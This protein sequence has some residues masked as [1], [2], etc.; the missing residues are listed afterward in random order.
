MFFYLILFFF[1]FKKRLDEYDARILLPFII[2]KGIGLF[3]DPTTEKLKQLV[4]Q[5]C[6]LYPASKIVMYLVQYGI[7]PSTSSSKTKC[8]CLELIGLI[9]N[10][11]GIH[12]IVQPSKLLSLFFTFTKDKSALLKKQVF[13]L[14]SIF[15]QSMGDQE[16]W[17]IIPPT[18]K[19]EYE[20][21]IKKNPP[22]ST[23]LL[24][25]PSSSSSS[26]PRSNLPPP[27]SSSSPSPSNLLPPSSS[28][29]L[30]LPSNSNSSSSPPPSS[31]H[32]SNQQLHPTLSKWLEE[33]KT[34][35]PTKIIEQSKL[36]S[37][38][39][40]ENNNAKIFENAVNELLAVLTTHYSNIFKKESK[41]YIFHNINNT[42][43]ESSISNN[44]NVKL[45]KY[46]INTIFQL[47]LN[48]SLA[49]SISKLN[50]LLLISNILSHLADKNISTLQQEGAS[51]LKALNR[52]MFKILENCDTTST[53]GVLLELLGQ[54]T[55][56]YEET[57]NELENRL[58]D[59][60]MKCILK[61]T[62][63]LFSKDQNN[64]DWSILLRD[65]HLFLSRYS[66][67]QNPSS[68]TFMP[69]KTVKTLLNE[70][71]KIKSSSIFN[72]LSLVPL[73]TPSSL[74]EEPTQPLIRIYID[75]MLKQ[76]TKLDSDSLSPQ[77]ISHSSISNPLLVQSNSITHTIPQ[78]NSKFSF[79]PTLLSSSSK[80][81]SQNIDKL[82]SKLAFL[83]SSTIENEKKLTSSQPSSIPTSQ[84]K[85]VEHKNQVETI[86]KEN[87]NNPPPSQIPNLNLLKDR[88]SRIKQ[89]VNK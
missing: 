6:Q 44:I 1:I 83:R 26:L 28:S 36:I 7:K 5:L 70:V 89:S 82:R 15:H 43:S 73:R 67:L 20:E 48:P 16:F 29:S 63:S 19:K 57:K 46:L 49:S 41:F 21:I 8:T 84:P 58:N 40:T 66:E 69:L 88:L 64:I 13:S 11:Q 3:N 39:L 18:Q 22:T 54:Y 56:S 86:D 85:P 10:S 87:S 65:I 74:S 24:S 61:V 37:I 4:L 72:F 80:T 14:I 53:L 77:K 60:T 34:E 9:V 68:I 50:I 30:P 75:L 55:L 23:P 79:D 31:S 32:L 12:S 51:I 38:N 81:L 42:T 76:K 47:V 27:S 35:D 33:M 62:K 78:E 45:C 71:V 25:S 17:K 52:L 59:F 2:G